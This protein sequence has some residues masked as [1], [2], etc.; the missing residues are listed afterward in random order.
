MRAGTYIEYI[1]GTGLGTKLCLDTFVHTC[2]R[3]STLGRILH[4]YITTYYIDT[5]VTRRL[6]ARKLPLPHPSLNL[7]EGQKLMDA[8]TSNSS[9]YLIP[10]IRRLSSQVITL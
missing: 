1:A 9:M 7:P 6:L 8:Q 2:V 3:G 5:Y 10:Q 4:I